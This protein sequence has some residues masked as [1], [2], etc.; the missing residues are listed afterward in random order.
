[1]IDLSSP[2]IIPAY[3]AMLRRG[4]PV[5][6]IQ[7]SDLP[8]ESSPVRWTQGVVLGRAG[9]AKTIWRVAWDRN[10]SGP[11][12]TICRPASDLGCDLLLDE[13]RDAAARA[14]MRTLHPEAKPSF[15]APV[16]QYKP[17]RGP[18]GNQRW[19]LI[20]VDTHTFSPEDVPAL[21]SVELLHG[22]RDPL[23]F[24]F[25]LTAVLGGR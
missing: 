1:M 16:F 24:R 8:S 14:L 9:N 10:A 25:I 4:L 11:A 22:D 17:G 21:A 5:V 12:A 3:P 20:G 2:T 15:T 7:G 6:R 13:V 19:V 18:R 23:A